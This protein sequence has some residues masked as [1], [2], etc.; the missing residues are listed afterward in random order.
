[1]GTTRALSSPP[2]LMM[3]AGRRLI[4]TSEGWRLLPEKQVPA[5]AEEFRLDLVPVDLRVEDD[6]HTI[7]QQAKRSNILLFSHAPDQNLFNE[8]MG[9][10][11]N[12]LLRELPVD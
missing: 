8:A 2:G 10:A 11:I 3:A 5:G 12:A 4:K 9:E 6:A 1:M 7:W